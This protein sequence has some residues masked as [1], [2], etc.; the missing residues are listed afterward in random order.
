MITLT[1]L[2]SS[3][4]VMDFTELQKLSPEE[5]AL[6]LKLDNEEEEEEKYWDR[7]LDTQED[8]IDTAAFD[9]LPPPPATG[10]ASDLLKHLSKSTPQV[11]KVSN[12]DQSDAPGQAQVSQKIR[13]R[14]PTCIVTFG[15]KQAESNHFRESH[16]IEYQAKKASKPKVFRCDF[17]ECPNSF[18]RQRLLKDHKKRHYKDSAKPHFCTVKKCTRKFKTLQERNQ[19]VKNHQNPAKNSFECEKCEKLFNDNSNLRRHEKT[20]TGNPEES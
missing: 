2:S 3:L 8:D 20:C 1:S 9:L 18:S 16:P 4:K 15:S 17:P 5:I 14:V 11:K 6:A 7:A 12:A 10:A 13:C 19:H